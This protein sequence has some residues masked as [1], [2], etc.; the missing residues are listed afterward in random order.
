M[1][2]LGCELPTR[3]I[4]TPPVDNY[5]FTDQGFARFA[6]VLEPAIKAHALK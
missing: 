2:I 4:T 3:L 5:H 6:Q 1:S